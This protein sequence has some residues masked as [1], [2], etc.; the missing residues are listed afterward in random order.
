MCSH[1]ISLVAERACHHYEHLQDISGQQQAEVPAGEPQHV[2]EP[3]PTR[4]AA[5]SVQQPGR[6]YR[7]SRLGQSEA[8]FHVP[9]SCL[10]DVQLA[11]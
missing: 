9:V 5:G 6:H 4:S 3:R 1:H 8:L 7:L 10:S 11:C 2:P